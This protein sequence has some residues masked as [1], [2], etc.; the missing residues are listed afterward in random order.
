MT[1][2]IAVATIVVVIIATAIFF[3]R[4]RRRRQKTASTL[5]DGEKELRLQPP[6][7]PL[8]REL[9][10]K[11]LPHEL[12]GTPRQELPAENPVANLES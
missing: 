11:P 9:E 8:H 12:A 10:D 5:P 7:T 2:A 3:M 4:Q 6:S 1:A